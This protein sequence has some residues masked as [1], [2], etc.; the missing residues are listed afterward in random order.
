MHEICR[1]LTVGACDGRTQVRT[2]VRFDRLHLDPAVRARGRRRR[3]RGA[4]HR[5]GRA[6]ARAGPRAAH[7]RGLRAGRGART[8]AR[9]QAGG[10]ALALPHPQARSTRPSGGS[11]P[12]GSPAGRARGDRCGGRVGPSRARVVR[13]PRAAQPLRRLDRRGDRKGAARA[14]HL[15]ACGSGAVALRRPRGGVPGS[16]P[17]RRARAPEPGIARRLPGAAVRRPAENPARRPPRCRRRWSGSASARSASSPSCPSPRWPTGSAPPA[18]S[19]ESSPRATTRR[20]GLAAP[21]RISRSGWSCRSR[22][23]GTSSSARSAC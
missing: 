7:R 15:G 12:V 11:R 5:T 14:Q 23:P 4:G 16:C 18:R 9:P 8:Q 2:C 21:R 17:P 3:P 13:L 22:R 19:P 10:G 6:R 1:D 20:S